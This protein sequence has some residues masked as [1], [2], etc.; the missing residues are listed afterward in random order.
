[1]VPLNDDDDDYVGDHAAVMI[2][3]FGRLI[4]IF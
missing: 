1:M 2:F 3:G 4:T